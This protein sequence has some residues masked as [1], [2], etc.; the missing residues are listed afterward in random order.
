MEA[1]SVTCA[2]PEPLGWPGSCILHP[3]CPRV[4]CA[5]PPQPGCCKPPQCSLKKSPPCSQP[6]LLH[7]LSLQVDNATQGFRDLEAELLPLNGNLSILTDNAQGTHR[8]AAVLMMACCA[9]GHEACRRWPACS[10][11]WQPLSA[12]SSLVALGQGLVCLTMPHSHP[13]VL[14]PTTAPQA[15]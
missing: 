4:G 6:L 12:P 8:C 5:M 10:C 11:V 2:C 13:P 7:P 14:P 15:C 1:A 9:G 3:A